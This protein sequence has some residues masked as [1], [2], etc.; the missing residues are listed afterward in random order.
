M[1]LS[2]REKGLLTR[3]FGDYPYNQ[4]FTEGEKKAIAKLYE[5]VL[6][7]YYEKKGQT[8]QTDLVTFFNDKPNKEAKIAR[9]AKH[10]TQSLSAISTEMTA[11]RLQVLKSGHVFGHQTTLNAMQAIA[12]T[13]NSPMDVF[14]QYKIA[15][16]IR[17]ADIQLVVTK[18]L[19][20]FF[21]GEHLTRCLSVDQCITGFVQATANHQVLIQF[22]LKPNYFKENL[23]KAE[24]K[25]FEELGL[26]PQEISVMMKELNDA[27]NKM[28]GVPEFKLLMTQVQFMHMFGVANT[29]NMEVEFKK[30][31]ETELKKQ[32]S[33]P[34]NS[35]EL[36]MLHFMDSH[37]SAYGPTFNSDKNNSNSNSNSSTNS[38][39][40]KMN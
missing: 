35:F 33:S 17:L 9:V 8:Y 10:I 29:L 24:E 15:A 12:T 36:A 13:P 2:S 34:S 5:T 26:M 37:F 7:N 40:T 32:S 18:Y 19:M 38:Q 4:K 21:G 6:S 3:L 23:Q 28:V 39:R 11:Q 20:Q 16:T 22:F 30:L 14:K 27:F 31:L 1:A 25:R